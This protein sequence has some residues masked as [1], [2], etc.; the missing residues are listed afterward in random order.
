MALGE[1]WNI[2]ERS[3]S[4]YEGSPHYTSEGIADVVNPT[5][6]P[7]IFLFRSI[8]KQYIKIKREQMVFYLGK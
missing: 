3:P 2:Y 6:N 1:L 5:C 8:H 4:L 7:G